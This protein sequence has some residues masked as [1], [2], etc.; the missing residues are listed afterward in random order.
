M[1]FPPFYSFISGCAK[2]NP[3]IFPSLFLHVIHS[4]YYFGHVFNWGM[5]TWLCQCSWHLVQRERTLCPPEG[6]KEALPTSSL[7]EWGLCVSAYVREYVPMLMCLE[8]KVFKLQKVHGY[9]Q[10]D[11]PGLLTLSTYTWFKWK[12]LQPASPLISW[13]EFGEKIKNTNEAS[14]ITVLNM[15]SVLFLIVGSHQRSKQERK[16]GQECRRT[17]KSRNSTQAT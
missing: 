1:L 16:K 11:L 14:L 6:R 8:N 4:I 12:S 7:A 10:W 3:T 9:K 15:Q 2:N 5:W 13:L 17:L